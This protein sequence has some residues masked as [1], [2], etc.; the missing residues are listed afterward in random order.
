MVASKLPVVLF[1]RPGISICYANVVS[2]EF[3]SLLLHSIEA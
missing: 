2:V 3:S 1:D